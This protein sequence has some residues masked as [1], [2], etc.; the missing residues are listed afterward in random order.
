MSKG[1]TSFVYVT[2]IRS[3]PEKVFEAITKPVYVDY[4]ILNPICCRSLC[5]RCVP[6][7]TPTVPG[8]DKG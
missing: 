2:Y 3:T 5:T 7:S 8:R 4:T 1:K 6:K